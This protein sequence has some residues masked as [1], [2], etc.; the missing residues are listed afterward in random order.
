MRAARWALG[1][2]ILLAVLAL[3][4]LRPFP[5]EFL[6]GA[7][8]SGFAARA[9]YVVILAALLCLFRIARGPTS[10]DRIMAIDI[11][12]ILIVGFCA[13]LAAVTGTDWYLDIGI[14]WA[15]QSFIASLAFA[16]YLERR[17]FDA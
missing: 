13:I 1:G 15:L 8:H 10:A 4:V 5:V 17:R 2:V 12:G 9:L 14:A 6:E 3:I 11:L 16:K 7:T